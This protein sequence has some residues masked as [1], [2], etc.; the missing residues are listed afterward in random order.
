MIVEQDLF[1]Q[2]KESCDAAANSELLKLNE[3]PQHDQAGQIK[4]QTNKH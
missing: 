2:S 1:V 3:V 4:D